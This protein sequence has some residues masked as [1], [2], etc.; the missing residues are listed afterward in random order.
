MNDFGIIKIWKLNFWEMELIEEYFVRDIFSSTKINVFHN[1]FRCYRFLFK[2]IVEAKE[3][4]LYLQ[5]KIYGNFAAF[6]LKTQKSFRT[7]NIKLKKTNTSFSIV[8]RKSQVKIELNNILLLFYSSS[9][10]NVLSAINIGLITCKNNP[11]LS[12]RNSAMIYQSTNFAFIKTEDSLY[13]ICKKK[14]NN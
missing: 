11:E 4:V 1:S 7:R 2:K 10:Q 12:K 3:D 5:G 14:K 6:H 9:S 13:K 8:D